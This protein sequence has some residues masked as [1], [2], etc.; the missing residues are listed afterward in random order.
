MATQAEFHGTQMESFDLVN[1][2]GHN[3]DCTFGLMGVRLST[4]VPH[5]ALLADQR[6]L[7][8]LVWMRRDHIRLTVEEF[9]E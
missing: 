3:C 9:K 2:I 5:A 8:G 6:W 1:A 7:D 4:C